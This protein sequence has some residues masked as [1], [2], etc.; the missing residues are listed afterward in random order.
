MTMIRYG[1]LLLALFS[2]A[3]C[4]S[5]GPL[6]DRLMERRAQHERQESSDIDD[7]GGAGPT[8][9]VPAGVRVLRDVAYGNDPLQRFD[10]Y[11]PAQLKQGAPVI[12]MVHGGGWRR[13]DK[14]MARVVENKVARWVPRGFIFIS[15][16]YRM[17]PDTKPLEQARDVAQALVTAQ[18]KAASWGGDP[19]K[20]IV[21]G[22]SAGAHLVALLGVSPS[23]ASAAGARP[24]LATIPLDS[25]AL[26]VVQIMEKRHMRLYDAAFGT[27]TDYW[28]RTSPHHQVT[29]AGRPFL[30]V[31]SSRRSDSCPPAH[32]F[33]AKLASAGTQG[34]VLEERM[35]HKEINERLGEE[36]GYTA[37]VENFMRRLDPAVA[38]LL[39]GRAP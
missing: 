4:A 14:A 39:G 28:R 21:M 22:H 6:R 3:Q 13:G 8:A 27:D 38:A 20:F 12:F 35:T 24:W 25:A 11:L 36:P 2:A 15:A 18:Q 9:S 5:S 32:A 7:E 34:S 17:L 23:L 33:V 16:N 37:A 19:D 26:D 30:V 1:A 29:Q 31:C 10:V